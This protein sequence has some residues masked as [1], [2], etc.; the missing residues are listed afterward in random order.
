MQ[1]EGRPVGEKSR[2]SPFSVLVTA[3]GTIED[4]DSVRGITNHASGRLGSLIADAFLQSGWDVTFLCGEN[5]LRPHLEPQRLVAIRNTAQLVGRLEELLR[6]TPFDCVVHSMAVSDFTPQATLTPDDLAHYIERELRGGD[7]SKDSIARAV[8]AAILESGRR[9]AQSK[10]SSKSSQL[11]LVL[12]QTP[13]AIRLIKAIQPGALLVGFKL[14]SGAGEPELLEAGQ[15]LMRQSGCDL[16]L[17][18]D[19]SGISGDSHRAF[20]MDKGSIICRAQTKT[21]I[22]GMILGQVAERVGKAK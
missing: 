4:I 15:D 17:A 22:A 20:L 8:Q 16:V 6:E 21:E 14:L 11:M 5:S 18:N 2:R 10:I 19:L 13:K 12:G 1:K 9:A 7:R 3:G